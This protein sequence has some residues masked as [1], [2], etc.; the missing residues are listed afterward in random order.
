MIRVRDNHN[1]VVGEVDS[2][3]EMLASDNDTVRYHLDE[4]DVLEWYKQYAIKKIKDMRNTAKQTTVI[5]VNDQK[6]LMATDTSALSM[7]SVRANAGMDGVWTTE[8]AVPFQLTTDQFRDVLNQIA[9]AGDYL[10]LKS[11]EYINHVKNGT[12]VNFVKMVMN[13]AIEEFEIYCKAKE[14][15]DVIQ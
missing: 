10:Y 15:N 1:N 6:Y 11:F 9:T 14:N 2:P 3:D 12:N 5:T 13:D 4:N 7:F 8:S